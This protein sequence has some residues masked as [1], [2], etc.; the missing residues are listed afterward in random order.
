MKQSVEIIVL[1]QIFPLRRPPLTVRQFR[2]AGLIGMRKDRDDIHDSSVYARQL[3]ET[4]QR[5]SQSCHSGKNQ[6]MD[7]F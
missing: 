7:I 1:P 6:K 5:R 4:A 3:R 2:Q